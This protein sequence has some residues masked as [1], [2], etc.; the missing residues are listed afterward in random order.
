MLAALGTTIVGDV[1]RALV[2]LLVA[3]SLFGQVTGF[4]RLKRESAAVRALSGHDANHI[5][6]AALAPL[7]LALRDWIESQLPQRSGTTAAEFNALET[8]LQ[9]EL[10]VAGLSLAGA[11]VG[12]PGVPLGSVGFRFEWI[13]GLPSTMFV[14]ASVTVDCGFDETIYLYRF[15]SAGRTRVLED[16]PQSEWG[17]T[18]WGLKLSDPDPRGRRLLLATYTSVQCASSWAGMAYS[19][20]RLGRD[21]DSELLLAD[22]QG[23]YD[24]RNGGPEFILKPEEMAIE[25]TARSMDSGILTR[26]RILR[27]SFTPVIRRVD[28]VALRPQDFAEEWLTRP[29]DEMQSRSAEETKKQHNR[30]YGDY[31][32]GDYY[33][34][35]PCEPTHQHWLITLDI[36]DIG[37]KKL[38]EPLRTYFLLSEVDK[39]Q[40]RME[41]VGQ[42]R[43]AG[44]SS[45]K[46]HNSV[47][48]SLEKQPWLST[49][50][51][52]AL[53]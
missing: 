33:S 53:R 40:Y 15:D 31:I 16:H 48:F 8:R 20:Y 2:W 7:H 30:L 37:E 44:C 32:L 27:Y 5:P 3:S 34:V 12:P 29:W 36:T 50:E 42:S 25:F 46:V 26:T 1:C 6:V 22:Q 10:R 14:I 19:V 21:I 47:D 43:P 35:A 4:D 23:F 52:E 11:Q 13:P 9:G 51:L 24:D 18:E 38:N 41:N 49:T 39:H 17:Y 45:G 28:P